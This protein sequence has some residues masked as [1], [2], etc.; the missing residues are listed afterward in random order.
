MASALLFIGVVAVCLL[1]LWAS[2][3]MEPH[4]VSKDRERM[5]C[6]GQGMS[7]SGVASGKWREM[8]VSKVPGQDRVVV[9]PRRG[10]LAVDKPGGLLSPT[11]IMKKRVPRGVA[12]NV[13]GQTRTTL[14]NRVLYILDGSGDPNLPDMIAIR[15]PAKS[16]AIPTLEALST[17]KTP[18][19]VPSEDATSAT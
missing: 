19:A 2:H 17:N 1:M 9:Q 3:K 16:K 12:W 5:V 14:K 10:S 11:K 7:R 18:G 6:F 8:R 15:L 4:W 13:V